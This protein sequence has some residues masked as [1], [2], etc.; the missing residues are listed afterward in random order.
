MLMALFNS[1]KR[2]VQTARYKESKDPPFEEEKFVSAHLAFSDARTLTCSD[3]EVSK[4]QKNS[5]NAAA[6]AA[7]NSLRAGHGRRSRSPDYDRGSRGIGGR[8][9]IDRGVIHGSVGNDVR[10]RD[11]YRPMRSPSPRGFRGRDEYRGRDRSP[12]RY[13][14][15]R[16]SRSKS[17]FG[18]NGRYRSRSP[19]GRDMDDEANLS[20]P[21]RNPRDVPDVQMILVD[22]VD[23]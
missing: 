22:E 10:R 23:R 8:P 13:Y 11:D 9:S 5:R 6:T 3:L 17:P 18:R 16:R 20:M 2:V 21:R 4:P 1:T 19:R 7:G 14:G 15:S 12:D